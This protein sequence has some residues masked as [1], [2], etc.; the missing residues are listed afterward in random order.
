[1]HIVTRITSGLATATLA[2]LLAA[3]GGGGDQTGS[4]SP[5]DTAAK[6]PASTA[7]AAAPLPSKAVCD[8]FPKDTVSQIIGKAVYSADDVD[9]LAGAQPTLCNYYTDSEKV[10]NVSIQWMTVA[11][12][13][14]DDQVAA[15]GT[16]TGGDTVRT[17]VENLGDDAIKEVGEIDGVKAIVYN[18][19]LKDRGMV[20]SVADVSGLPET[21][22][23]SLTKA[24]IQ[25]AEK[26]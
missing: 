5:T 4:A 7:P 1:V 15:I 11:D 12:A 24:V 14:W 21:T 19:L 10:D 16:S 17:R 26:L 13:L 8:V 18:V 22:V 9:L 25:T 2:F 6:Q 23:L 3:C 20:L